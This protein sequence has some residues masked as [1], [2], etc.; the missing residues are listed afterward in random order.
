MNFIYLKESVSKIHIYE[1]ECSEYIY[2]YSETEFYSLMPHNPLK[3][4]TKC[5][6]V[7]PNCI[8]IK[9]L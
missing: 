1:P 7:A 2:I 4:S 8:H 3:Q 5:A 9:S 6:K